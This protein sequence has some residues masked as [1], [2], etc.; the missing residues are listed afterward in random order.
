LLSLFQEMLAAEKRAART[1]KTFRIAFAASLALHALALFY[2]LL[3]KEPLGGK[4]ESRYRVNAPL[5][6]RLHQRAQVAP[7]S[8]AASKPAQEVRKQSARNNVITSKKG[9]WGI[10]RQP[11][12]QTPS[13]AVL[14]QR[15][16]AMARGMGRVEEDAGEDAFSTLQEA[17][18]KEIEPLS[19]EWYFN[20]FVT[21]LNRS[22]RFV[23]RP[24]VSKG[25]RAAEVR[26]IIGR[27][28]K[29][30]DYK[31]VKAADRQIEVAYI[32]A[33]AKQ[34]APFA[35]FPAD[36]ANKTDTLSLTI[37][38]Q[39]PGEDGGSGG[40]TRTGTNHC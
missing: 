19:L 20:S 14:A 22:A 36:I 9:S 24:P 39:P 23:N 10:N 4:E 33:V 31:I 15:A 18:L 25:Q 16:L 17:K 21:K 1:R 40:F 38:I 6:A 12:P 13:G 26:L 34:A 2:P 27:D 30:V 5:Q 37:C 35:P 28:G 7:P 11:A 8:Q 3:F 29:L 32:E